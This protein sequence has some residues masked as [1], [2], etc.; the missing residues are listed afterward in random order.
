M[1]DEVSIK[2]MS[3][4]GYARKELGTIRFTATRKQQLIY[5]INVF[6][7]V[8]MFGATKL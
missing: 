8:D 5:V 7:Y 1:V 6:L 4:L 2:E 3:I